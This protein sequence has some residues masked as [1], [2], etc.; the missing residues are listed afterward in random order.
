MPELSCKSTKEYVH[1]AEH[2]GMYHA[3]RGGHLCLQAFAK[4]RTHGLFCS[5]D[6]D[7]GLQLYRPQ[8]LPRRLCPR[9]EL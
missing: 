6:S 8:A 3:A 1:Q 2:V 7:R 5:M 4:Y 9:R